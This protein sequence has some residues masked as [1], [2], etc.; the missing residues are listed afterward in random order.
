MTRL[1][2]SS[3]RT[4]VTTAVILLLVAVAGGA[5]LYI[6]NP[7]LR[8]T[9]IARTLRFWDVPPPPE[10][11]VPPGTLADEMAKADEAGSSIISIDASR[12]ESLG[13]Q[14][15]AAELRSTDG[16]LRTTG[17]VAVD[18]RRVVRVTTRVEG[19]IGKTYGDFEGQEIRKGQPLYTVYSPE[20][21][22]SQQEYLLA[23]RARGDFD[24][25]EFESVRGSGET[26]AASARRRLELWDMSPAQIAEIERT[27]K[28]IQTLT[29]A[30][31]ASGYITERKA[32]PGTR[33][34]PDMELYTLA[35]LSS[36]WIDADVFEVDLAG[37][38]LGST[39]E[40]VLPSGDKRNARVTYI[41]PM[42]D[43]ATRT[44]KVRLELPNPKLALKPGMFVEVGLRATGSPLLVI[45]RDAVLDTGARKLVL[46]DNGNGQF[47]L[48]EVTTGADRTDV[49][50]IASGLD[51]GDRVARNIQ[52]LV[53]SET[54]LR[55]SVERAKRSAPPAN[56][57][58]GS[59]PGMPG[60]SG[61]EAP[62]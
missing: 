60:M 28:P 4:I 44:A 31:P 21:L 36:I 54:P 58:G 48:R 38:R 5:L 1:R 39:A 17:R 34:S 11:V 59:M 22:A 49:T 23:L 43:P 7:A 56:A 40:I 19:W 52:F 47:V 62:K 37:V 27:G 42:V 2:L 3:R 45:P 8:G 55:E 35:D 6:F 15:V 50:V 57:A 12:A 33:I 51:L 25:S 9:R 61:S 41:N 26:L 13:L 16:E 29:V 46:V 18:E 53:D 10:P 14:T 20:L 24:K 32:F 30:A